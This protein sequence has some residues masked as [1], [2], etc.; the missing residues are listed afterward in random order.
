MPHGNNNGACL[1]VVWED[2]ITP[3]PVRPESE[4][5]TAIAWFAFLGAGAL[6]EWWLDDQQGRDR[7]F[8][9]RCFPDQ[10]S[11]LPSRSGF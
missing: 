7:G 9:Q 2:E 8:G 6:P 11:L 5:G 1:I 3:F 10:A 4:A